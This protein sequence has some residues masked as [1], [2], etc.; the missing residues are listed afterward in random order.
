MK[1][2]KTPRIRQLEALISVIGNG[3]MTSAAADMGISQPAISRLLSDLAKDFDFQLFNKRDGQLGF[4][5]QSRLG[6]RAV[7]SLGTTKNQLQDPSKIVLM[8]L[9]RCMP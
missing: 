6:C 1:Q 8:W 9:K 7:V 3:S 5:L 4:V 2:T